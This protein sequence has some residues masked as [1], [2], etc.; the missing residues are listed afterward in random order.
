MVGAVVGAVVT[1]GPVGVCGLWRLFFLLPGVFVGVSRARGL[2]SEDV[3]PVLDGVGD[4][5]VASNAGENGRV[6]L[7]ADV[8]ASASDDAASL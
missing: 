3:D 7:W 6:N 1:V 2:L 8:V 4:G 5:E